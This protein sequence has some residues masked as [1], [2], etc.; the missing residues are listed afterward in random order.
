MKE[1]F[2]K[3][4]EDNHGIFLLNVYPNLYGI[5]CFN[6]LSS[7]MKFGVYLEFFHSID[8]KI[9]LQILNEVHN[10]VVFTGESIDKIQ[11]EAVDK[12]LVDNPQ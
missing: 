2:E 3:W 10:K 8:P 11:Q 7:S 5:T 1:K 9:V 6:T 12:F 4:L